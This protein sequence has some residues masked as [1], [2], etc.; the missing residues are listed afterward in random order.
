[1]NT[2]VGG[3]M[4][5]EV[6]GKTD[7]VARGDTTNTYHSQVTDNFDTLHEENTTMHNEFCGIHSEFTGI[8]TEI[9]A[10]HVEST[11]GI[12]T[13]LHVGMHIDLNDTVTFKSWAL[14]TEHSIA[15]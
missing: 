5:Q 10:A 6:V 7:T 13:E 14:D 8:H 11:I 1:M 3:D 9:T 2:W 4:N 12:H 15:A